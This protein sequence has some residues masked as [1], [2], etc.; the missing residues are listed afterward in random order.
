MVEDIFGHGEEV[1]EKRGRCV[2][3]DRK[4]AHVAMA[5]KLRNEVAT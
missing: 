4:V 3:Y 1:L 2:K 5:L